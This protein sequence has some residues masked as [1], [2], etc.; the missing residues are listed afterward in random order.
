MGL[1]FG[2]G[3]KVVLQLVCGFWHTVQGGKKVKQ[4]V[5]E[6]ICLALLGQALH[7]VSVSYLLV[8]GFIAELMST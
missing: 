4:P 8:P 7:Y 6:T 2:H 5:E 3:N 1:D